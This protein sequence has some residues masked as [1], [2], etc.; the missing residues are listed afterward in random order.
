MRAGVREDARAAEG[1]SAQKGFHFRQRVGG[2]NRGT[3]KLVHRAGVVASVPANVPG[4]TEARGAAEI[5]EK[6]CRARFGEASDFGEETLRLG[7]MVQ[8][9]IA[10][11]KIKARAGERE[12]IA[13]GNGKFHAARKIGR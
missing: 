11:D 7:K 8:N 3:E 5:A 1:R 9:G 2:A 13:V 12:T 6:N 4:K 10:H